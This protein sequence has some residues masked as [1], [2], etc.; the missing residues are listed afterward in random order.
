M[1][2]APICPLCGIREC[3]PANDPGMPPAWFSRC[4]T[5]TT[6]TGY[7]DHNHTCYPSPAQVKAGTFEE[8]HSWRTAVPLRPL[9]EN[10]RHVGF[11]CTEFDRCGWQ[12][13]FT[14]EEMEP[15]ET[16]SRPGSPVPKGVCRNY[17]GHRQE[18]GEVDERGYITPYGR[19][20]EQRRSDAANWDPGRYIE[21]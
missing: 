16:H 1:K 4:L 8:G 10:G 6:L 21:R 12:H 5:C 13:R 19:E 3:S 7:R 17:L 14:P 18:R 15:C 11:Q 2:N 20:Q 9:W